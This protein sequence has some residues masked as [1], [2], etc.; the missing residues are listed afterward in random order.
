MNWGWKIL[1]LYTSFVVFMLSLVY[2]CTQQSIDLVTE[3][4]YGKELKYADQYQRMQNSLPVDRKLKISLDPETKQL[5]IV[6]PG[7][8]EN[9]DGTVNFFR[10]DNKNLDFNVPV[11]AG[12]DHNQQIDCGKL[13]QGLWRVQITWN[14]DGNGYYEDKRIFIP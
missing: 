6:F 8:A 9:V 7:N 4:Y 13:S 5:Q 2:M 12:S 1:I 14:G 10:P 11:K 3:N